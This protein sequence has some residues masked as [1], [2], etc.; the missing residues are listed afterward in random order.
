VDGGW[1]EKGRRGPPGEPRRT[2]VRKEKRDCFE[3][4]EGA[5]AV[6]GRWSSTEEREGAR[7][8]DVFVRRRAWEV[9]AVFVLLRVVV[10]SWS[11]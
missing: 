1:E 7:E 4:R 2:D 5:P 9:E 6:E 3:E 8:S 11:S 10:R